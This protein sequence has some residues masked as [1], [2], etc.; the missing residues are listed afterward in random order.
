MVVL[1]GDRSYMQNKKTGQKSKIHYEDGQSVLYMWVPA[2][3]QETATEEQ[4]NPNV[5]KGNRFAILAAEG[6]VFNRQAQS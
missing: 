6:Q 1:D 5:L 3:P 4:A 2:P